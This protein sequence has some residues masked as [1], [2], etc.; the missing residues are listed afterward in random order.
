MRLLLPWGSEAR[1]VRQQRRLRR[2][3][4]ENAPDM[5][6]KVTIE[7]RQSGITTSSISGVGVDLA[8]ALWAARGRAKNLFSEIGDH[9]ARFPGEDPEQA[10]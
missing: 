10:Q 5:S 8:A 2:E 3:R 6:V 7:R 4:V 9:L 1:A